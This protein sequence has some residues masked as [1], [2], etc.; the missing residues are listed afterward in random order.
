ME[1]K[2]LL[3]KRKY[4]GFSLLWCV[5]M[6]QEKK[7]DN[8][9]RCRNSPSTISGRGS[10]LSLMEKKHGEA[11]KAM[12]RGV[13]WWGVV[14]VCAVEDAQERGEAVP[15]P[16]LSPPGQSL[17]PGAV[18]RQRRSTEVQNASSAQR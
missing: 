17:L 11:A 2:E 15:G 7:E 10:S 14:C 12:E 4:I 5:C 16:S 8:G 6:L 13:G 9:G 1:E 18:S 3:C